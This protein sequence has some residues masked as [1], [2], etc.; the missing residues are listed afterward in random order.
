[1]TPRTSH[2]SPHD[3]S[4]HTILDHLAA[5]TNPR[6]SSGGIRIPCPANG[7]TNPNLALWG[8]V[9][10]HCQP[11]PLLQLTSSTLPE[12]P[13]ATAALVS[14]QGQVIGGGDAV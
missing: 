7:G 8:N 6:I 14:P 12:P 9:A 2:I 11:P 13:A 5:L 1:M 4:P 10:A 3:Q